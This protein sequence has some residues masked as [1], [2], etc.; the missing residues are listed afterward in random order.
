MDTEFQFG[1][2]IRVME[3]LVM[4]VTQHCDFMPLNSFSLSPLLTPQLM[5]WGSTG[6][7]TV[8][9][10]WPTAQHLDVFSSLL[11]LPKLMLKKQRPVPRPRHPVFGEQDYGQNVVVGVSIHWVLLWSLLQPSR[12]GQHCLVL[13]KHLK[14]Y[15]TENYWCNSGLGF[16]YVLGDL[17]RAK[18][19]REDD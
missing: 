9:L 6:H 5:V 14:R 18:I 15:Q 11:Q 4:M 17:L 1:K 7:V 13:S 16:S 19:P 12:L 2:R 8:V 10:T 3:M